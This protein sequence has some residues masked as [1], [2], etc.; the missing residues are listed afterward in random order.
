MKSLFSSSD[1]KAKGV[2]DIVHSNMC[3]P[4]STT[5]FNEY[6]YCVSFID[7]FYCKTWI[8]FL[9][10]KYEVFSKFKNFNPLMENISDNGGEFTSGEFKEFCS[11]A[12]IKREIATP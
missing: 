4:M 6:V 1:I 10:G 5:P 8:Y 11:E 2:L 9:K 7:Y 3:G 12:G